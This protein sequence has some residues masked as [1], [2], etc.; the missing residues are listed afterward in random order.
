M[1]K[2]AA[3]GRHISNV[4]AAFDLNDLSSHNAAADCEAVFLLKVWS[5]AF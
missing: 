3:I 2:D 1:W 4:R 5:H